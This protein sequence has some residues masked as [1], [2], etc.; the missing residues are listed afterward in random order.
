MFSQ[1]SVCPQGRS[2]GRVPSLHPSPYNLWPTPTSPRQPWD[3]PPPN[4]NWSTYDFQA[5][6][7]HS[8]GMLS[9]SLFFVKWRLITSHDK[10]FQ[11]FRGGNWWFIK[12]I[13]SFVE[14]CH[15]VYSLISYITIWDENVLHSVV[16]SGFPPSGWQSYFLANFGSS[17]WNFW[18]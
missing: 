16:D 13:Q 2:H 3:L 7:M 15:M 12:Y 6:D 10:L 8:T 17:S 9:C 4:W 14:V 11:V 18:F 5:G 1:P